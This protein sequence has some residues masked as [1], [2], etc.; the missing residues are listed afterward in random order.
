MLEPAS[1]L[2]V[3]ASSKDDV[4]EVSVLRRVAILAVWD[5]I[6]VSKLRDAMPLIAYYGMDRRSQEA[7]DKYLTSMECRSERSDY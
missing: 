3:I 2:K 4:G 6:G 7:R 1:S 5:G